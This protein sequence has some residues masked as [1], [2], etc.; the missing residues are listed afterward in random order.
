MLPVAAATSTRTRPAP[1]RDTEYGVDPSGLASVAV[2]IR[3]F[4]ISATVQLGGSCLSTGV[5]PATCGEE[6]EV[7]ET[8]VASVPVPTSADKIATPGA[9]TSGLIAASLKR[10]PREV[11]GARRFSIETWLAGASV[12]GEEGPSAPPIAR[13]FPFPTMTEG[14]AIAAPVPPTTNG[15][16][17]HLF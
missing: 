17:P 15:S 10:G 3:R 5:P 7:P 9:V 6:N 12:K 8:G 11:N 4:W 16:P 2:S 14:I 13:P 1:I